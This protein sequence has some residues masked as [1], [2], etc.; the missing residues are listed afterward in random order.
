M[1][2]SAGE[3]IRRFEDSGWVTSVGFSPDGRFLV[4]GGASGAITVW[5]AASGRRVTTLDGHHSSVRDIRLTPDRRYALSGSS[6]GTVRLWEL[7]WDLA[8]PVGGGES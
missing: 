5:D 6:D 7:D 4:V 2:N 3:F 1:W 8:V